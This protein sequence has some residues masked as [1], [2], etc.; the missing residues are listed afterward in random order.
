MVRSGILKGVLEGISRRLAG[1]GSTRCSASLQRRQFC[2]GQKRG[3][4]SWKNEAWQKGQR[5]WQWQTD[6]V[7][8]LPCT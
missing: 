2:V 8:L 5:S 1:T 3:L 4:Q 6:Q 7:S